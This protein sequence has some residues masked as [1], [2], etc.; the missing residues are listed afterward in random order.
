VR[1]AP[2]FEEWALAQRTRLHELALH[3]MHTL[4]EYHLARGHYGRTIDYAT[5]LLALDAW[6]EEAHR[7]MMLALARS[8][9]RSAAL[10]Q[11]QT[12][13][14][15]LSAELGVEPSAETTALFQRIQSAGD[16][17]RHNLPPQPTAFVGRRA[18]VAQLESRLLQSDC[19]MVT[20]VGIGGVG[21]TRLALQVARRALE[22][23]LFLNG[24]TYVP[25]AAVPTAD[26]VPAA[27]A[28]A[29]GFSVDGKDDPIEQ[30]IGRLRQQETLIVL[31]NCEHVVAMAGRLDQL[32]RRAPGVKLL[33]TS[34]ERLHMRWEWCF[35]VDGLDY[36]DEDQPEAAQTTAVQLFKARA[37]AVQ[38]AIVF[39]DVTLRCAARICRLV[40]GLPLGIELAAASLQRYT[41]AAV[42][43]HLASNLDFLASQYRDSPPRHRTLRAAFDQ[44]L[45]LLAPIEQT[46][47]GRLSVFHGG[48]DNAAA[49]ALGVSAHLLAALVDKSLVRRNVDGRYDLHPVLRQFSGDLLAAAQDATQPAT[50]H[51]EHYLQLLGRH[52][53]S[54]RGREQKS[55]LDAI[56]ADYENV[57]AAWQT[58][59]EQRAIDRLA[60]AAEPLYYFYLLRSRLTEGLAA[61]EAARAAVTPHNA[62][63]VRLAVH[64]DNVAAKL[65]ISLSRVVEAR[66]LLEHNLAIES[67]TPMPDLE[68][69]TQRYYGAVLVTLGELDSAD[70]AFA[71]SRELA[72]QLGDHWAEANTLLDWARL[73]FVR[74]QLTV[75]E[76]RC[77]RGLALAEQSGELLL[78]ANFLTGLSIINREM[79]RIDVAQQYI[80]RSLGVYAELDD[81]YGL[82][83]GHLS[84]GALLIL[85]ERY[86][87]AQRLFLRALSGSQTIGFRWGEADAHWRLGQAA[88]GLEEAATAAAHW[89]D[90]LDIALAIHEVELARDIVFDVVLFFGRKQPHAELKTL[91]DWLKAQPHLTDTQQASLRERDPSLAAAATG[92]ARSA[93]E[94]TS[95][96]DDA[97]ILRAV[98][99]LGS[100]FDGS[101]GPDVA[102]T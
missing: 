30:V 42:A 61:F 16:K 80:E 62:E 7:Q 13:R 23:G 55:A 22:S 79:G 52:T 31:D 11:Y 3:A 70:S 8:G 96:P 90:G 39:D 34:R 82:I 73:A 95:A 60:L 101:S 100:I 43:D 83:Q 67:A 66:P 53:A 77:L 86:A 40:A 33:L 85:R 19:R 74:K 21:K 78:I 49:D 2:D 1:D 68:T 9:Q 6:R 41:C 48:F 94:R 56:S 5:R 24:V 91:V 45:Q 72:Q 75:C 37:E 20:L 81:T 63:T 25:L 98:V 65:L 38:P 99:R 54:L 87:D 14:R 35:P 47:F 76:E 58:A 29:V 12:C 92:A 26:L 15:I 88:A 44:S 17:P 102:Q 51:S 59:I 18:E 46:A 36:A 84:L 4:T 57:R 64:I 97:A 10:V 71:R 50:R 27:V 32:L 69:A 89:R 28:N 93:G